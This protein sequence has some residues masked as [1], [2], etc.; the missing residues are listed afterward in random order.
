MT[1][2]D[3]PTPVFLFTGFLGSGKTT[4]LARLMR[5]ADL[6]DTAVIVNEFGEVG[7]DH[8]LVAQGE[9]ESV[10]LLENGCL[11][12][13]VGDSLGETLTDLYY[14]REREEIPRFSRVVIET[15]GMAD[16]GPILRTLIAD[17]VMMRRFR[18]AAL[19]TMVDGVFGAA[20]VARHREAQQQVAMADRIVVTKSDVASNEALG[21]TEGAARELNPRAEMFRASNGDIEPAALLASADAER[22]ALPQDGHAHSHS[23]AIETVFLSIPAP[24]DWAQYAGIVRMLQ[25]LL[26]ARLLRAKGLVRIAGEEGLQV[27]QGVQHMFAPPFALGRDAGER[28]GLVLIGE[29]LDR[30][31]LLAALTP[32]G[33]AA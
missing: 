17:R 4:V 14:R 21:A 9:E 2:D 7:L 20:Q 27:I 24:I 16:P 5:R 28:T 1:P 10:V 11:C 23:G 31:A 22:V 15:T 29:G 8:Q 19:V 33:V 18:V 32:Y 26:G 6:A 25:D 12:C 3:T 30:A 13:A